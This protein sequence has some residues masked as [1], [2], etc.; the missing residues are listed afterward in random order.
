MKKLLFLLVLVGAAFAVYWFK[1]RNANNG[2]E[3]PK[4][5]PLALKKHSEAFNKSVDSLVNAYLALKDAFVEADTILVKT[6]TKNFIAILDRFP[7]DELK[8]DT[9]SIFAT[10]QG[11]VIDIK[12]NAAS[13]LMQT[14]IT[15]MRHD[16][17]TMT[18]MMFPSFFTAIK[19]EGPTLYFQNC[20]MAFDDSVSANWI[21][22]SEEIVNPYMGKNHP[23]YHAGMLGCGSVKDSIVAK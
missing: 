2:P 1:F 8:K 19:Y 21:S 6:T 23:T 20:P 16:F 11:N 14:N 4:Q 10:V 15:E 17:S 13:I 7:I 12:S 22:N 3:A 5:A 9:A 18:E